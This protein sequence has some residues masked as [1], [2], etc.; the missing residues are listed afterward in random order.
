MHPV[1]LEGCEIHSDPII[2]NNEFSFATGQVEGYYNDRGAGV[3]AVLYEFEHGKIGIRDQLA[4]KVPLESSG[5]PKSQWLITRSRIPAPRQC[6]FAS[7][8][9]HQ[10]ILRRN[11][12]LSR[13]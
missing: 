8:G 2:G 12:A 13:R 4:T 7:P 3:V 6:L 10:S 9:R 1:L 5:G 11:T